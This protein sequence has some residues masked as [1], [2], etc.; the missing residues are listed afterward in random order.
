MTENPLPAAE[1][2][3]RRQFDACR[4]AALVY[5]AVKLGLPETMGAGRWTAEQLAPALEASPPHLF[6]FLRALCV[7]GICEEAPDRGFTLAPLGRSL[8]PGAP[9]RLR[10]KAVLTV[11][12]YWQPWARLVHSLKTGQPAF[13]HVFGTDVWD[14]RRTNA[15]QGALFDAYFAPE[16]A[17]QA[18]S[19]VAAPA[20]ATARVVA[21]IGGGDGALLAA[22]L[23][24]HPHVAGILLDRPQTIERAR[25]RFQSP[26]FAGR[27]RLVAGDFTTG[28]PVE[29]D[30]YLLKHVLHD[31]NDAEC[32]TILAN[33]RAAVP[34]GARLLVIEQLLPGRAADDPQAVMLDLHMMVVTGGRER[35]LDEFQALL[36]QSGFAVSGV[37][38][39]A[40]GVSVIEAAPA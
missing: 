23:E 27:V 25:A 32:R 17:E 8:L 14:W 20:F 38:P 4:G 40:C 31:W 19:I 34:G 21:D 29:A 37:I 3:L 28:I 22:V 5:A 10:E 12:Q 13:D 15:A 35:S 1:E 6:R 26:T 2:G 11:E 36:A 39:A 33:C 30:L 9:A 18:K 16:T 24:A 7:L